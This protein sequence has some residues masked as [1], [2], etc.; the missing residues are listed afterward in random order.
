MGSSLVFGHCTRDRA[1]HWRVDPCSMFG[2]GLV[3]HRCKLTKLYSHR[4]HMFSLQCSKE[5]LCGLDN[6]SPHS[7]SR[8]RG[9]RFTLTTC[10]MQFCSAS[11]L[12]CQNSKSTKSASLGPSMFL[13]L[14]VLSSC[15]NLHRV[16]SSSSLEP[17]DHCLG[18]LSSP[19]H[20]CL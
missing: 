3:M 11:N 20:T 15:P 19:L 9:V 7:I 13:L 14:S 5:F 1:M 8:F 16:L 4:E 10:S 18:V 17:R 2:L 12:Q 6:R